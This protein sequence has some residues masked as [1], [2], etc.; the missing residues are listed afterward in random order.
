MPVRITK[1]AIHANEFSRSNKRSV[2]CSTSFRLTALLI[3]AL[4]MIAPIKS[5]QATGLSHS[6]TPL[7]TV[8]ENQNHS[9]QER[10]VYNNYF[11]DDH[12]YRPKRSYRHNKNQYGSKRLYRNHKK[13]YRHNNRSNQYQNKHSRINNHWNKNMRYF[14]EKR[15][16]NYGH[17]SYDY[18]HRHRRSRF[19]PDEG[20]TNYNNRHLRCYQHKGHFHCH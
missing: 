8:S 2:M 17:Q 3:S 1:G 7:F 5:A 19:C 6:S 4:C 18:E 15:N 20:Y 10:P 13:L 9:R 16:N 14:D 12:Y 11:V